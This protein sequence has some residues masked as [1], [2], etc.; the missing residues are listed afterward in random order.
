MVQ[1]RIQTRLLVV[2]GIYAA[3]VFGFGGALFYERA[4]ATMEAELGEKLLA[5]GGAVGANIHRDQRRMLVARPGGHVATS[6]NQ[7]LALT[8]LGAGLHQL[9]VFDRD[10]S[11]LADADVRDAET[12]NADLGF[13]RGA[14][15]RVFAGQPIVGHL[16]TGRD[17]RIYKPAYLPLPVDG[18]VDAGLAVVGSASVLDSIHR[19]R[20]GILIASVI[21]VVVSIL[22]SA[23]LA[24]SIVAPVRSLVSAADRIRSGDL[25]TP[26]PAVGR[27]EVGYLGQ[28]LERMRHAVLAR[29]R[30]LRAMLGGVAHEI[31]NPIGGIELF[32]GLLRRQ[33][34]DDKANESIDRIVHE[35]RHLDHIVTDFLEY[36]RPVEP[37]R[38]TFR[39]QDVAEEVGDVLGGV[40]R[41]GRIRYDVT[42][43]DVQ[44]SADPAQFRRVLLNLVQNAVQAQ[45]QGGLVRVHAAANGDGTVV[46]VEDEGPGIAEELRDRVFEPF[47]TT[48]QQGSGLGL[49]IARDLVERNGGSLSIESRSPSGVAV[50]MV[51]KGRDEGRT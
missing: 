5:V 37:R 38:E 34:R 46:R 19:L 11:V 49:S 26:V 31:R 47:F 48:R 6:V 40:I 12:V 1:P 51:W 21:G 13:Q 41:S 28:T 18:R 32:A 17:G 39:V 9:Y 44:L 7:M 20:Q 30:S 45:A 4:R 3:T 50:V 16:F 43:G 42:C 10:G 14:I 2:F 27:D 22:T 33:V 36:A 15:E 24:R 29:E 35:V 25:E 8:R 23:L